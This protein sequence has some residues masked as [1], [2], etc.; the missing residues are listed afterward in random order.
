VQNPEDL[1]VVSANALRRWADADGRWL[2]RVATIID[3]APSGF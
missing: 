2:P 3:A 1:L